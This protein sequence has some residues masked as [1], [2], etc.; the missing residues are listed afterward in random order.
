[1][2]FW[3]AD[4]LEQPL[5]ADAEASASSRLLDLPVAEAANSIPSCEPDL[6][7]ASSSDAA[8]SDPFNDSL[9]QKGKDYTTE[10]DRVLIS[11]LSVSNGIEHNDPASSTNHLVSD[12][13]SEDLLSHIGIGDALIEGIVGASEAV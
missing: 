5:Q 13:G 4:A 6:L 1:M 11:Q 9:T 2:C 8:M 7:L 10:S 3:I 12:A